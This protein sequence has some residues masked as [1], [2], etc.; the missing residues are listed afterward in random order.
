M[1]SLELRSLLDS[2]VIC[3]S[4]LCV[5]GDSFSNTRTSSADTIMDS[6]IG[7]NVWKAAGFFHVELS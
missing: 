4:S 2:P 1:F 6:V 7:G 3:I 5:R